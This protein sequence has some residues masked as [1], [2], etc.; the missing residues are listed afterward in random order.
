VNAI[1]Q[2]W[3]R[4]KGWSNTLSFGLG[5][6]FGQEW[7]GSVPSAT[8]FDLTVIGESLPTAIKL[9]T[10]ARGGTIWASKRLIESLLPDQRQRIVFGIDRGFHGA[11][12]MSSGIYSRVCDLMDVDAVDRL[13]LH[14]IANLA[15]AQIF[16]LDLSGQEIEKR[17]ER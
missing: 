15:V 13:G 10:F 12:S 1:D 3:K 8:R 5:L 14:E 7:V 4:K 6:H 11:R 2:H 9:A 16:A 17:D